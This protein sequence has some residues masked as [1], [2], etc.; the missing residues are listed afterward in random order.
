MSGTVFVSDELA[1][2][3]LTWPD[4][5]A[6]LRTVYGMPHEAGISP[7]RSLARLAP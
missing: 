5:I 2:A 3:V 6:T 7:P 4:M 1:K